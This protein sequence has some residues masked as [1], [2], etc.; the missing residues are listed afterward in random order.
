MLGPGNNIKMYFNTYIHGH[1][2]WCPL[3]MIPT[4]WF[5][6]VPWNLYVLIYILAAGALDLLFTISAGNAVQ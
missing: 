4:V 5:L 3:Q 1:S 2:S 6:W